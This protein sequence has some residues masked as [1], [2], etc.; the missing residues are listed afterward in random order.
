MPEKVSET[1][2]WMR[3]FYKESELLRTQEQR[4]RLLDSVQMTGVDEG[5]MAWS[6]EEE[7]KETTQP[8]KSAE[9]QKEAQIVQEKASDEKQVTSEPIQS[10]SSSFE[11]VSL[12]ADS[13]KPSDPSPTE[14]SEKSADWG[15]DWE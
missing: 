15:E 13:R 3:Y 4:K 6:D 12:P 10:E 1:E 2:F 8:E 11:I 5:D 14:K 9:K 7:E